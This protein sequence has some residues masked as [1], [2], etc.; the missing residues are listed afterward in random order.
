[1][2]QFDF[3]GYTALVAALRTANEHAFEWAEN[4]EI[5]LQTPLDTVTPLVLS[6]EAY[7]VAAFEK[8][9]LN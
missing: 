1:M 7:D 2:K 3:P 9:R 5:P 8:L 6:P 4:G